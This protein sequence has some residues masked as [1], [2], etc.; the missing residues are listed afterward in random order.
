MES[1][2]LHRSVLAVRFCIAAALLSAQT[3][4]GSEEAVGNSHVEFNDL[5]L[6]DHDATR[7]QRLPTAFETEPTFDEPTFD[8]QSVPSKISRETIRKLM[9]PSL[10]LSGEWQAE[11]NDIGLTFFGGRV[12]IPTYPVF[13]PPPPFINLGFNYTRIAAPLSLGLPESLYET[14]LGCTWIR[15]LNER[16]ML[17]IMAGASFATD[18]QNDS[19]DA[20]R[21]RGGVFAM[22]R[23]NA[24]WTWTFGAIALGRND[25][26]VVPAVG[27]IHQPNPSL[28]FDLTMP[29]PRIAF[30]L[31]DNGPRQRWGYLGISLN[32][33]TWGAERVDGRLDQL[34]YGDFRAVLG[35]ESVPT[36][37]NGVPF[38]RGRKLGVEIGYVFSR[39][40]EWEVDGSAIRLDDV[41][42]LRASVSF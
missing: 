27:L 32:G 33:T 19:D 17:R 1:L 18:G 38:T 29:R 37:E 6:T 3:T 28:R 41:L 23:R 16:W 4:L 39:D 22:Y 20:W 26:P 7:M 14:E 12:S 40:L 24:R 30:L 25:L 5:F 9:R 8:E 13:G 10:R 34:T 2:F 15:K 11:T 21:F 35:W 36:P 42:M 31:A